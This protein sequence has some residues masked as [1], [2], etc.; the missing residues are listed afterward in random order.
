MTRFFAA[1]ALAVWFALLMAGCLYSNDA[2][3]AEQTVVSVRW[4]MTAPGALERTYN[5]LIEVR[6]SDLR[7]IKR[8][9]PVTS[10]DVATPYEVR[11]SVPSGR[12]REFLVKVTDALGQRAYDGR[13]KVDLSPGSQSVA[14][15]LRGWSQISGTFRRYDAA[16]GGPGEPVP[17]A[18]GA[19]VGT[20]RIT[21]TT[22]EDGAFFY[23]MPN[24]IEIEISGMFG[25][26]ELGLAR[27]MGA[28]GG[29]DLM[30]DLIAIDP[31]NRPNRHTLQG[32]AIS[33]ADPQK[34]ELFGNWIT[35]A[36][37]PIVAI[38]EDP[39]GGGFRRDTV[40][41][42]DDPARLTV[43]LPAFET[44]SA[45]Y[46]VLLRNNFAGDSNWI[47]VYAR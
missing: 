37:D 19:V 40:A 28:L 25:G 33:S 18:K 4:A 39:D 5:V 46:R 26:E 29:E 45:P 44:S 14:V 20:D 23:D 32:A 47:D 2:E 21:V 41:D 6:A 16:T 34:L 9:F 35:R 42:P 30:V 15:S 13:T 17:H 12:D 7:T 31:A 38:I 8:R 3:E 43:A 22:D 36:G 27:V 10:S 1:T 24:G 11:L